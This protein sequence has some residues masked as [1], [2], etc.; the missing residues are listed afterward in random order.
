MS[1]VPSPYNAATGG[2]RSTPRPPLLPAWEIQFDH[3]SGRGEI[4]LRVASMDD[5]VA[6]LRRMHPAFTTCRVRAMGSNG[7]PVAYETNDAAA[8]ALCHGHP[9]APHPLL[10]PP[11]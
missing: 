2:V 11:A 4:W 7:E 8:N 5:A 10:D 3:P 1:P 6:E 9:G